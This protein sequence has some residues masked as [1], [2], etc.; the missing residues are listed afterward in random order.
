MTLVNS[1]KWLHQSLLGTEQRILLQHYHVTWI[2]TM[3]HDQFRCVVQI[4]GLKHSFINFQ[5]P[6]HLITSDDTF[7][8][9]SKQN[10]ILRK[11]TRLNQ[12]KTQIHWRLEKGTLPNLLLCKQVLLSFCPFQRCK[13]HKNFSKPFPTGWMHYAASLCCKLKFISKAKMIFLLTAGQTCA[14]NFPCISWIDLLVAQSSM[15]DAQSPW[16]LLNCDR[17]VVMK[18]LCPASDR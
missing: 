16:P 5:S 1:H 8:Y 9:L 4:R 7:S 15:R 13:N 12:L 11:I 18:I 2:Q 10:L 17:H 6:G 3:M 14:E